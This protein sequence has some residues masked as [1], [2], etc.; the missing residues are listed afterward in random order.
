MKKTDLLKGMFTFLAVFTLAIPTVF[1]GSDGWETDMKKAKARAAA[2]G[3]DLLID[4]TGS[5]WCGWCIKLDEEV[6]SQD[7]F[8]NV[9][10]KNFVLVEL[11]F[12]RKT[13]LSDELRAQNAAMAKEMNVRGYPTIILADATGKPYAKTG[14]KPGGPVPYNEHLAELREKRIARDEALATAEEKSGADRA[15]HLALALKAVGN[16]LAF[17]SHYSE[18]VDEVISL[19]AEGAGAPLVAERKA[20]EF[21]KVLTKAT[22]TRDPEVGLKNID[23]LI[24][25]SGA[26]GKALQEAYMAKVNFYIALDNE[27]EALKAIDAA[28]AV[29]DGDPAMAAQGAAFKTRIQGIFA[30]NRQAEE[31]R[32][33]QKGNDA[34]K[35]DGKKGD[36]KKGDK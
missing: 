6:F 18:L 2:E 12:P 36:G 11:D 8:K 28:V 10:P 33:A 22:R 20:V 23:D 16:E 9:S 35:G 19:D 15:K 24:A 30:R 13:V 29:K 32:N 21:K 34:K 31:R 25:S 7:E 26:T 27:T 1:A 17:S 4:F 14:Y 3:K 5:D